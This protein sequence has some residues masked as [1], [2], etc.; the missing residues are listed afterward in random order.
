MMEQRIRDFEVIWRTRP[1][2]RPMIACEQVIRRGYI[3]IRD[4]WGGLHLKGRVSQ[5]RRFEDYEDMEDDHEW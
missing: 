4:A 3:Y 5:V 1:V 2:T